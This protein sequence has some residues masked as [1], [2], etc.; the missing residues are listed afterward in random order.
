MGAARNRGT[1]GKK[2]EWLRAA[3]SAAVGPVRL[4][5]TT[6]HNP[7]MKPSKFLCATAAAS[8][9]ALTSVQA[10][11]AMSNPSPAPTPELTPTQKAAAK[12]PY[13]LFNPTPDNLLRPFNTD[14]PSKTDSPITV[15]AGRFQLE[16]DFANYTYDRYNALRANT[17]VETLLVAPTFLK[18]GLFQNV[19]LQV[20]IPTYVNVRT[21]ARDV[22]VTA[23]VPTT[24]LGATGTTTGTTR[25]QRQVTTDGGYGDMFVRLKVNLIGN[26]GGPFQL[27]VIPFVKAPTASNDLGN[28]QV[29]GGINFPINYSLPFSFTLF[30]Q[31]RYDFLYNG[32][33]SGYHTLFSNSIGVSRAI[34]GLLD[35]KL[36]GYA[37]IASAISSRESRNDPLVLTADT[38]VIYQLTP[39][40]AID[41]DGFFGLT[42]GAPDVNIFGGIGV[43]F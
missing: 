25:T 26:E 37:E 3:P 15:D 10:G 16:A 12:L 36:S 23:P 24:G 7:I 35:G 13:N 32:D 18:V 28:G 2:P 4:P 5:K 1:W 34:P 11:D 14:R 31:T 22:V 43:R 38:G 21:D 30:A 40:I 9:A 33:T 8:L 17:R 29:E 27:A 39:N 41:V 19:D 6:M 20:L 42:R